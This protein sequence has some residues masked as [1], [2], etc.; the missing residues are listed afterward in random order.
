M[1]VLR[2]SLEM[3]ATPFDDELFEELMMEIDGGKG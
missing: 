2:I 1:L 3:N